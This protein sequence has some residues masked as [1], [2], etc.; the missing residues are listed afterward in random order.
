VKLLEFAL[1]EIWRRRYKNGAI[2]VIFA[3]LVALTA[4]IFLAAASIKSLLYATLDDQPDIYL[5]RVVAGRLAPFDAARLD[6]LYDIAGIEA[7]YERVW[8]YYYFQ[9]AGVNFTVVGVD[10]DFPAFSR[11]VTKVLA[12]KSLADGEMLVGKGV[13]DLLE[14]HWY[15]ERFNFIRPDGEMIEGKIAGTITSDTL[16]DY[17]TIVVTTAFARKIFGL[18]P[19]ELTDVAIDLANP[20]EMRTIAQ[21]L[22]Y[23]YPDMRV[24]T[25]EDLRT[26]YQNIFDYKSGIFLAL[27]IAA[28]AAFFILVFER[29]T[30]LSREQSRQIAI[31]KA[32]GW[33]VED[34]LKV[35]FLEGAIVSLL[36]YWVGILVAYYWI[37]GLQGVGIREVFSGFS[38]LKPPF[39]LEPVFDSALLVS[40]FLATV[41]LYIAATIVPNWLAAVS[42]TEEALR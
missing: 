22:R 1:L 36:S 17:D 5:Q 8:G 26:S 27:L 37:Y 30:A 42:D 33:R 38:V 34:I 25:K 21:K 12:A 41:P 40:I 10:P 35:K 13:R 24:I 6:R 14:R 15:K 32:L 11:A 3:A 16:I 20:A 9:P 39:V 29:S 19:G 7:V 23:L 4:A 2:F 28:F 31:L 18:A